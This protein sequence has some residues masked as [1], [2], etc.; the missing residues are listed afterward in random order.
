MDIETLT[1]Q[2]QSLDF[3]IRKTSEFMASAE[4]TG[5]NFPNRHLVDQQLEVMVKYSNI[6]NERILI[7]SG[8]IYGP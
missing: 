5:L 6:L 4:Y 3:D 2:K 1:R 8:G 7:F